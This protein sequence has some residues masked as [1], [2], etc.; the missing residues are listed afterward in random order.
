LAAVRRAEGLDAGLVLLVL[1]LL[2]E[3]PGEGFDPLGG[4]V[5]LFIRVG[6]GAVGAAGC[7]MCSARK[8][9]VL[10]NSAS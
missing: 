9:Q 5:R 3:G 4:H 8:L 7:S 2:L 6:R 10:Q 1:L